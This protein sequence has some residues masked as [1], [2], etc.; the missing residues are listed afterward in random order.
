MNSDDAGAGF[1]FEND[2]GGITLTDLTGSA[3]S[4]QPAITMN[5]AGD[6]A[7]ACFI[8]GEIPVASDTGTTAAVIIVARQDDQTPLDVRSAL[9]VRN[10]PTTLL[11]IDKDGRL[12]KAV[13]TDAN[14]G[15]ASA[16]AAGTEI[17]NSDDAAPNW[18][19]GSVWKDAAGVNT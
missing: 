6:D 15:T 7:K 1:T 17:W 18:S 14:R 8:V 16:Y 9:R 11:D 12:G 4:C 13:F 19:D 10:G 2:D 3:G 5:A